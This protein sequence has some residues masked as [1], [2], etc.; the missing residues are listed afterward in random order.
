HNQHWPSRKPGNEIRIMVKRQSNLSLLVPAVAYLWRSTNRQERP[1]EDQ[2]REIEVYAA[3]NGYRILR[4]YTD[5]GI[6]GDATEN[7]I[8]IS[9]GRLTTSS[10]PQPRCSTWLARSSRPSSGSATS[11][12]MNYIGPSP[13]I[14]RRMPRPRLRRW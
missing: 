7:S 12:R 14:A 10:G 3:H 2:R 11:Y 1:L 4:W 6:S 5:S 13:P 8:V 9:T